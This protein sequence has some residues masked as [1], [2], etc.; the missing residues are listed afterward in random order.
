MR[1]MEIKKKKYS[2]TQQEINALKEAVEVLDTISCDDEISKAIQFEACG[3]VND[4]KNIL[5]AI[6]KLDEDDINY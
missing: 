2:L 5:L 6:L 4:S 1:T 3:S